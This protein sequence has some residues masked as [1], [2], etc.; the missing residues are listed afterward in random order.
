MLTGK[1]DSKRPRCKD[2]VF[3]LLDAISS[4]KV[5]HSRLKIVVFPSATAADR[6]CNSIFCDGVFL[7]SRWRLAHLTKSEAAFY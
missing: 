3:F 2:E 7:Q 6:L 5:L 4:S 1:P